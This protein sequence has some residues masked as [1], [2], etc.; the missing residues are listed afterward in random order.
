LRPKDADAFV[1]SLEDAPA[2]L[3]LITAAVSSFYTFLERDTEG[4]L[5]NPVRGTRAR[6][7]SSRVRSLKVPSPEAVAALLER[8]DGNSELRGAV[9]VMAFRG[10]RVC[11]LPALTVKGSRFRTISKGK[12]L[13]GELPETALGILK[14]EGLPLLAPFAGLSAQRLAECFR[15]WAKKFYREDLLEAAYSVHDLRHYF[16]VTEY[17][18]D[19]D[20]YRVSRLLGHASIQITETYLRSLGE[21][22]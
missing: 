14:A 3:R 6:P 11:A 10:L 22:G 19:R 12:E 9:A 18:K 4:R 15:Y 8:L 5:R 20:L 7:R 2:S 21:I 16:A 17:R 13:L 1:H